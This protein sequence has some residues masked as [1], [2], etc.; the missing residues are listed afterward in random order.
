MST[1]SNH[2]SDPHRGRLP[3]NRARTLILVTIVVILVV[4]FGYM[5][6]VSALG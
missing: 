6:L 5:I 2:P 4:A 3:K 1:S